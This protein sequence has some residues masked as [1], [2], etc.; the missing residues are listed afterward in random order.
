[1]Y[2]MLDRNGMET[3]LKYAVELCESEWAIKHVMC[4]D[5]VRD[6]CATYKRIGQVSAIDA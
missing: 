4:E 5:I 3:S 1:M 6:W 2:Q